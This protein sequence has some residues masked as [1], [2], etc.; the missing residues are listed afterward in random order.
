MTFSL[1]K[2]V[3]K[4]LQA[5]LSQGY[6]RARIDGRARSLDE[7]IALEPRRVPSAVRDS[8]TMASRPKHRP[9]GGRFVLC[10][11][12]CPVEAMDWQ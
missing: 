6:S 5:L 7:P 11:G 4:E 9:I 8:Y 12:I 2:E 1:L 10:S 3:A